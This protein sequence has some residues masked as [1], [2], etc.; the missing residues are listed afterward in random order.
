MCPH[1]G[2]K[3]VTLKQLI[4]VYFLT[5]FKCLI[6][7]WEGITAAVEFM[8]WK[9]LQVRIHNPGEAV[10]TDVRSGEPPPC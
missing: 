2:I 7:Q 9:Q 6:E 4:K 10:H 1:S 5:V 8:G 3:V